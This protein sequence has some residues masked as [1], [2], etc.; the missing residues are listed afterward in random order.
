MSR[1]RDRK[2]EQALK[3]ELRAAGTPDRDAC[4]DAETLG[5]W[6]DG[7]LDAVQM[8]AVELHV[9]TCAR[10]QAIAGATARSSPLA[11]GA[12][13]PG[14]FSLWRWWLAPLAAT[15]AA[16]TIW[17]VVPEQPQTAVT[18]PPVAAPAQETFAQPKDQAIPSEPAP[19]KPA[20]AQDALADRAQRANSL[21]AARD[22][23]RER[24]ADADKKEA[25][26]AGKP[27][28][29]RKLMREGNAVAAET[30]A[31]MPAA[32]PPSAP[33]IGE[34][35]KSAR[36]AFAAI[37]IVSPNP[38]SRW[39]IFGAALERSENS[40]TTWTPLLAVGDSVTGGTAPAA[41]ICWLIGRAGLVMVTADGVTFARVPLPERVDVTSITATDAR[42]ATV[43]T[44]D[45]RRFTTN[46]S[47]RNWRQN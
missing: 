26:L 27:D 44:A 34:L 36:L 1:D 6:A 3:H 13:A 10:C 4:V 24:S 7:G 31:A 32:A 15:A 17:M 12:E 11:S 8:A 33:V 46:D 9:S 21:E 37:E 43:T 25:G 22:D 18:P 41:A 23:R 35:Q 40:G 39:R 5:A 45:G 20:T 19:A 47:G 30:A 14:T 16:V 42:A 38:A 29:E 2:L 28:E